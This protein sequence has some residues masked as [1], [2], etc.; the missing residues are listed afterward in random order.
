MLDR[1]LEVSEGRTQRPRLKRRSIDASS[2]SRRVPQIEPEDLPISDLM[3]EAH[4]EFRFEKRRVRRVGAGSRVL[5]P[6][7]IE[8]K[9]NGVG[10]R[11]SGTQRRIC[12]PALRKVFCRR[13]DPDRWDLLVSDLP[14]AQRS[15]RGWRHPVGLMCRVRRPRATSTVNSRYDCAPSKLRP[16]LSCCAADRSL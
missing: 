8:V 2:Q 10:G 4:P 7:G 12:L 9:L 15:L 6:A 16:H 11:R 13:T 14:D 3:K 1:P 5:H